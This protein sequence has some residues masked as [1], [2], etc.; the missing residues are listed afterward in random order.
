M[1]RGLL[2]DES[3]LHQ[4]LAINQVRV[5][6]SAGERRAT[7]DIAAQLQFNYRTPAERNE[8][9][10]QIE[11]LA[12]DGLVLAMRRLA[13]VLLI[14]LHSCDEITKQ[15]RIK[16]SLDLLKTGATKGDGFAAFDLKCILTQG[17]SS[18]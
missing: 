10:E 9:N 11:S 12:C 7:F 3:V 18:L 2:E 4:H 16:K 13:G 8:A 14:G 1:A 15:R 5:A 17:R 6:S